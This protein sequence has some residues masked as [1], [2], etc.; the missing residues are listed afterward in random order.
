MEAVRREDFE[1]ESNPTRIDG[2]FLFLFCLWRKKKK[3]RNKRKAT[4]EAFCFRWRPL[5]LLL[6]LLFIKKKR[7]KK[8]M[9]DCCRFFFDR[10]RSGSIGFNRVAFPRPR[11][12]TFGSARLLFLFFFLVLFFFGHNFLFGNPVS[13]ISLITEFFFFLPSFSSTDQSRQILSS[14]VSLGFTGFY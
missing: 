2:I 9:A 4:V 7:I 3:K 5:L 6:L 12:F 11:F 13:S 1:S 8:T 14:F 10:V